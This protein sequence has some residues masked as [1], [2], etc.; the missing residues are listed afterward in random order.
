LAKDEFWPKPMASA[1]I[2]AKAEKM[3]EAKYLA[4]LMSE[5]NHV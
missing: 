5:Q 3:T 2:V 4:E 1:E